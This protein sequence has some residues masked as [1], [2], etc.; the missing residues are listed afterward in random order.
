[1]NNKIKIVSVAILVVALGVLGGVWMYSASK[2][3][4]QEATPPNSDAT[5]P[6]ENAQSSNRTCLSLADNRYTARLEEEDSDGDGKID[7]GPA[8]Q[9]ETSYYDDAIMCHTQFETQHSSTEIARLKSKKVESLRVYEAKLRALGD[10]V[11]NNSGNNSA[12]GSLHCASRTIGGTTR[13]DC[14]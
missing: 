10:I 14:Y 5:K 4:P 9:M 12:G 1:M 2:Q 11:N 13:T 8:Y 3:M 6:S 7:F